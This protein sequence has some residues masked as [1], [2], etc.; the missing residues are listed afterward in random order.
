MVNR[1][2]LCYVLAP[3]ENLHEVVGN[4]PCVQNSRCNKVLCTLVLDIAVQLI[5]YYIPVVVEDVSY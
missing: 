2:D 3:W 5:L 4:V 1:D